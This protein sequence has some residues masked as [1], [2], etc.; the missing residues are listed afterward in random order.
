MKNFEYVITYILAFILVGIITLVLSYALIGLPLLA[1]LPALTAGLLGLIS[2][3]DRKDCL[4]CLI[5]FYGYKFFRSVIKDSVIRI[6]VWDGVGI[7][8]VIWFLVVLANI[9]HTPIESGA[10]SRELTGSEQMEI[11]SYTV[12][13]LT[14]RAF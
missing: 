7:I 1:S 2:G 11:L 3:A 12:Y 8:Y 5:P 4:K 13:W 9:S 10:Y 14:G 6:K